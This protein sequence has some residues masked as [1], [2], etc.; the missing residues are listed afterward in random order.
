MTILYHDH[1]IIVSITIQI[2]YSQHFTRTFTVVG[3]ADVAFHAIVKNV[4]L[5]IL[6]ANLCRQGTNTRTRPPVVNENGSSAEFVG[7]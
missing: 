7:S 5:T 1:Q 2:T 4:L 6:C 3:L